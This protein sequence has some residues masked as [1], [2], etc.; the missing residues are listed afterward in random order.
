VVLLP[1]AL[2]LLVAAVDKMVSAAKATLPGG[3]LAPWSGKTPGFQPIA[4]FLGLP[5]GL[6][7]GA[8]AVIALAAL[9]LRRRPREVTVPLGVMLAAL[10]AGAAW[11]RLRDAGALFHFR[12]LSFFAPTAVMLAGVALADLISAPARLWRRAAVAAALVLA[13]LQVVQVRDSLSRTFPH[14]TPQVW[15]LRQWSAR[16]PPGSSVRVDVTPVGVQQWAWYML[17]DH[18]V[19][20]THPL[21][22]FY[23]YPPISRKADFLLVNRPG[24]EPRDAAGPPILSNTTF[25]LYRMKASVPGPDRS[26]RRQV[27]PTASSGAE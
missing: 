9:G 3:D 21:R 13:A 23:P 15:Q 12:A 6:W 7:I 20:A 18:P 5:R 8:V 25:A 17:A 11:F 2:V 14:V 4:Y 26:S 1:I 10:L 19:S 22:K 16:L 27:I 24:R